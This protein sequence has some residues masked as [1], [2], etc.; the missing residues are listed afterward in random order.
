MYLCRKCGKWV[1]NG[2][3]LGQPTSLDIRFLQS[4]G[5]R[6]LGM[7]KIPLKAGFNKRKFKALVHFICSRCESDPSRLGA[8]KLNKILWYAET[9]HFLKTGRGLTGAKYIKRQHGPVPACVTFMVDE[10]VDEH[11]LFV[12]D[13][14]F[15]GREKKEYISLADPEIDGLFT[16]TEIG[17]LDRIIDAV[18]DTHTAK[19]ISSLSHN[20]AWNLADIG[21]DLPLFTALSIPG[22]ITEQD[23]KWADKR[24]GALAR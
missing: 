22:E 14:L 11:K 23:V 8:T 1:R 5:A 4:V 21:E 16:A 3:K 10:L 19:S 17:D 15:H 20:E 12:R 6:R 2:D 13:V 7:G 18:C 24:I 9:G